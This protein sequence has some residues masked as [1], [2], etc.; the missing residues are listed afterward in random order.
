MDLA[1]VSE[2]TPKLPASAQRVRELPSLGVT[3]YLIPDL[4]P[5]RPCWWVVD[6]G[7]LVVET[8]YSELLALAKVQVH[9]LNQLSDDLR[10]ATNSLDL[11][12]VPRTT[13]RR[14]STDH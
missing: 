12:P 2:P 7:G 14:R 1:A 6:S 5:E 10:G 13:L 4:P 8:A 3:I 11:P 9:A